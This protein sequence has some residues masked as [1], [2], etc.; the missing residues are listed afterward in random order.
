MEYGLLSLFYSKTLDSLQVAVINDTLTADQ[1]L[2]EPSAES[3]TINV[4]YRGLEEKSP[5][6]TLVVQ[7][8]EGLNDTL[9]FART[10]PRRNIRPIAYAAGGNTRGRQVLLS[11]ALLPG[12]TQLTVPFNHPIDSVRSDQVEL[13]V[14]N[15]TEPLRPTVSLDPR[16]PR[17]LQVNF[18]FEAGVDYDLVFPDSTLQDYFGQYNDELTLLL[19]VGGTQNFGNLTVRAVDARPNVAYIAQLRLGQGANQRI[20]RQAPSRATALNSP[21]WPPVP[22]KSTL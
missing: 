21:P 11:I 2:I 12:A 9:E 8:A 15:A 18:P 14:G 10:L 3:D 19:N 17:R 1:L 6:L 4:W 20:I 16:F 7:A 5:P 13:F 22:T